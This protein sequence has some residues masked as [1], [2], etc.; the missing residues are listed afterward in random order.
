MKNPGLILFMAVVS[1]GLLLLTVGNSLAQQAEPA[2]P[3]PSPA[4]E[5]I[6]FRDFR[7]LQNTVDDL[8]QEVNY[9][10]SQVRSLES[11]VRY[12]DSKIKLDLPKESDYR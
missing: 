11:K 4:L 8:N 3:P 7:R 12:L 1:M 5:S 2:A 6:T 9:L 10:K